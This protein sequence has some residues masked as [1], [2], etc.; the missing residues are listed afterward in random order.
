MD[1]IGIF[2]KNHNRLKIFIEMPQIS[3]SFCELISNK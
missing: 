3:D 1:Q 2:L